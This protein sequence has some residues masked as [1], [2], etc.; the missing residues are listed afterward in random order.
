M[1]ANLTLSFDHRVIDGGAA[2]RLL[3]R[4]ADLIK[5]PEKL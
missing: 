1:E 3:T 2:G 4:V 5:H